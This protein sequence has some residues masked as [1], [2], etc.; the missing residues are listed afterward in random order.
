MKRVK[1]DLNLIDEVTIYTGTNGKSGCS[2]N[3]PGCSQTSYSKGH[4]N[5]NYSG[6]LE[7]IHQLIQLLPNLKKAY[8]L[9]NPDCSV[10]PKF[11]SEAAKMFITNGIHVMFS[12][13]GIGGEKVLKDLLNGLDTD[14]VDYVSFSI[15]SIDPLTESI[16]K[17]KKVDYDILTSGIEYCQSIDIPIKIQPTIW[18][19]N[20]DTCIDLM[21]YFHSTYQLNRFTFHV[22]SLEGLYPSQSYVCKHVL[23]DKWHNTAR[24]IITYSQEN[25]LTVSVPFI[26]LT[27][28]EYKI[29]QESYLPHCNKSKPTDIQV[30]LEK[31]IKAT[32]FPLLSHIHPTDFIDP[33]SANMTS[34]KIDIPHKRCAIQNF[35]LDKT[36]AQ[37]FNDNVWQKD[38]QKL[39]YV[40]RYY[41][42]M[43]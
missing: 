38:N 36:L 17:G 5:Q 37:E 18:Q 39:F 28:E 3:C 42:Y 32:F 2:C 33:L 29:Y 41:K 16:L 40:C 13:S 10:D 31:D 20:Q 43:T 15:D 26:F 35:S 8:F 24:E 12:T 1:F 25:D 11:C 6:T 19:I 22:G 4:I 9:G 27:E 7:Q 14:F 21:D 30:W 23:P 34:T